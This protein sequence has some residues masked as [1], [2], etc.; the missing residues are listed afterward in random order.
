M[1]GWSG[2]A[3]CT[4][5]G[6]EGCQQRVSGREWQVAGSGGAQESSSHKVPLAGMCWGAGRRRT[7]R[8]RSSTNDSNSS[9]R[10]WAQRSRSA[11]WGAP[12]TCRYAGTSVGRASVGVSWKLSCRAVHQ[13]Q[14]QYSSTSV[15]TRS[16]PHS[17]QYCKTC[18]RG[19]CG[20]VPAGFQCSAVQCSAVQCSANRAHAAAPAG[21][22]HLQRPLGA[23]K[24]PGVPL[25]AV[26]HIQH[27]R[28]PPAALCLR[29]HALPLRGLRQGGGGGGGG[30]PPGGGVW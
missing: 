2:S 11:G 13:R 1:T 12:P 5:Q 22:A 16:S 8:A 15:H 14:R 25:V 26:A 28:L 6:G 7:G 4:Q 29:Q 3:L 10:G 18:T 30:R 23:L 24:V 17:M 9:S 19:P 27:Q 20:A 21:A